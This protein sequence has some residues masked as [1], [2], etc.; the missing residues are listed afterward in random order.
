[1]IKLIKLYSLIVLCLIII[2]QSF[3]FNNFPK[4]KKE[5]LNKMSNVDLKSSLIPLDNQ[6][7]IDQ[8]LISIPIIWYDN[9][10]LQSTCKLFIN[11][12]ISLMKLFLLNYFSYNC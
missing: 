6:S 4:I 10:K 9:L 1:M 11:A 3:K 12:L 5:S 7:E 8:T 2:V